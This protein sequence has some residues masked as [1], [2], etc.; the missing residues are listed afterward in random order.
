M[1]IITTIHYFPIVQLAKTLQPML[2]PDLIL[3]AL[4][5]AIVCY[6]MTRPQF[7]PTFQDCPLSSRLICIIWAI[8]SI[9]KAAG[10]GNLHGMRWYSTI[11]PRLR[12]TLWAKKTGEK[13]KCGD[14]RNFFFKS[15]HFILMCGN[16]IQ[17][18]EH[19]ISYFVK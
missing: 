19:T 8:R 13:T 18:Y 11:F 14:F 3:A 5:I 1:L 16:I 7:H 17:T 12:V 2:R 15:N 6:N 9:N 10:I 4:F